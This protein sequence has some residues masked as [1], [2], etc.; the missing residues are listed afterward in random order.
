MYLLLSKETMKKANTYID[1]ANNKIIIILDEEAPVKFSS[2]V[3][4]RITIEKITNSN[5]KFVMQEHTYFQVT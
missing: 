4:Y 5:E 2:S 3:H 1:F